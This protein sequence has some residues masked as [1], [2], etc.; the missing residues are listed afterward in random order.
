MKECSLS[1]MDE[2]S[3]PL[4]TDG[5]RAHLSNAGSVQARALSIDPAGEL[6]LLHLLIRK[7]R[8]REATEATTLTRFN[9]ERSSCR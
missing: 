3:K 7:Q 1:G 4:A 2:R 5:G 9:L 6:P 8:S